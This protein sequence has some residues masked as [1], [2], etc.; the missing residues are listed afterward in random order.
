MD[1]YQ[2]NVRKLKKGENILIWTLG[3]GYQAGLMLW[4]Y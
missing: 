1:Q 4:R 3:A 2:K